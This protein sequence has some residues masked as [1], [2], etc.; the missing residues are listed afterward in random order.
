MRE[1]GRSPRLVINSPAWLRG[2]ALTIRVGRQILGRADGSDLQLADEHVSRTHAA[3]ENDRGRTWIEDLHSTGGTFV[4]GVRV[5][6]RY[7]L[8]H[9][10][11]LRF[12]PAEARYEEPGRGFDETMVRAAPSASAKPEM[13]PPEWGGPTYN[14]GYQHAGQLSNV[15][16]NQYIQHIQAERESFFREMAAAKT[17]AR[18]LIVFGF[19]LFIAGFGMSI[20]VAGQTAGAFN[21]LF[22]NFP[23]DAGQGVPDGMNF[24]HFFGPNIAGIPL[25][26]VGQGLAFIGIVLMIVGLV[27]HVIA[28]A[29]RKS[30]DERTRNS[31]QNPPPPQQTG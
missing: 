28:A 14:V 10:D 3:L 23:N 24:D 17:R 29:R 12:G 4:N 22:A 25:I 15:A 26:V 20:W 16:G 13:P 19:F 6:G 11:V 27:L 30:F 7:Q 5:Q 1:S 21:D 31:W 8:N 2:S 18:R 9:G